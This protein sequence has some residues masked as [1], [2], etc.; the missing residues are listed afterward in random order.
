MSPSVI[1]V[2]LEKYIHKCTYI[3]IYIERERERKRNTRTRRGD[4]RQIVC[5]EAKLDLHIF[6]QH[7]HIFYEP[8]KYKNFKYW[9]SGR[10]RSLK[11]LA[12]RNLLIQ[13]PGSL[14]GPANTLSLSL[15]LSLSL[16]LSFCLSV[17][18]PLIIY[19]YIYI[20]VCLSLAIYLC[21]Y[22][23]IYLSLGISLFIYQFISSNLT[24]SVGI[25]L[26]LYIYIYIYSYICVCVCVC[27]GV[28]K[29]QVRIVITGESV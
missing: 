29:I 24:I 14:S 11:T 6:H 5:F 1:L 21:W 2:E 4:N 22:V 19:I 9:F 13:L 17:Y 27:G 26:S 28:S 8:R 25:S 10:T 20:S 18:L 23:S 15:F 12:P 7:S 16:S 3:Y